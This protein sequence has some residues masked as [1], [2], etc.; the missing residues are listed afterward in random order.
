MSYLQKQPYYTLSFYFMGF[1]VHVS[2]IVIPIYVTV[3]VALAISV[4]LAVKFHKVKAAVV[5]SC[6]VYVVTSIQPAA[7]LSYCE[8]DLNRASLYKYCIIM[9]AS[10]ALYSMKYVYINIFLFSKNVVQIH[11]RSQLLVDFIVD[12]TALL[13]QLKMATFSNILVVMC[14]TT[15]V[16]MLFCLNSH[17]YGNYM[18]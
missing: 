1:D 9:A 17:I 7:F 18:S 4:A 5:S 8:L 15:S 3:V 6:I 10:A 12:V 2:H 14:S 11:T 16:F 13:A